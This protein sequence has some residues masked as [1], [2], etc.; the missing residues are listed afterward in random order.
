[1]LSFKQFISEEI[2]LEKRKESKNRARAA[3]IDRQAKPHPDILDHYN[4]WRASTPA[5]KEKSGIR[6][7]KDY[8]TS[9]QNVP[10]GHPLHGHEIPIDSYRRMDGVV[11]FGRAPK[12]E[13]TPRPKIDH[14]DEKAADIIRSSMKN[15]NQDGVRTKLSVHY[16][17]PVGKNTFKKIMDHHGIKWP[18]PEPKI[19]KPKIEKPKIT[20]ELFMNSHN[21]MPDH[22]SFSQR[23]SALNKEHGLS[24]SSGSYQ[25]RLKKIKKDFRKDSITYGN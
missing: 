10:E 1:M 3:Y 22:L 17:T 24:T 23:S 9:I 20:D 14:T 4:K 25:K 16:D 7:L 2:D 21:K 12:K 5:E 6:T 8:H 11:P 13:V 19:E 15:T 18:K